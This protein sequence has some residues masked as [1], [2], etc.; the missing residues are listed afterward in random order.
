MDDIIMEKITRD[1]EE[2]DAAGDRLAAALLE[3]LA[4]VM[5]WKMNEVVPLLPSDLAQ[6]EVLSAIE[7]GM[8]S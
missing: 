6:R 2:A 4:L 5:R 3:V 7:K 1:L 8:T